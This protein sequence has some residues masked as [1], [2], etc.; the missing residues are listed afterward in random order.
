M[1]CNT[2]NNKIFNSVKLL[3]IKFLTAHLEKCWIQE[4]FKYLQIHANLHASCD[5][6]KLTN[7]FWFFLVKW[8]YHK[9]YIS[10]NNLYATIHTD[11]QHTENTL[12]SYKIYNLSWRDSVPKLFLTHVVFSMFYVVFSHLDPISYIYF[13]CANIFVVWLAR[14]SSSGY[15]W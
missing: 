7:V 15:Y 1:F 10:Q 5:K 11:V 12:F 9:L 8:V 2:Y 4:A 6:K 3:S 14:E 13:S